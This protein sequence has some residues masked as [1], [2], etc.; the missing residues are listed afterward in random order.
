MSGQRCEVPPK[1]AH[2][3]H[4]KDGGP[5]KFIPPTSTPVGPQVTAMLNP[6]NL[7]EGLRLWIV[8]KP[9]DTQRHNVGYPDTLGGVYLLVAVAV[10]ALCAFILVRRYQKAG[11]L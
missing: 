9:V 7:L 10:T 11:L 4:G 6:A 5:C 8:G 1:T 3:V 2:H